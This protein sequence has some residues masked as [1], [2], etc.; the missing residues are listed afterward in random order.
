MVCGPADHP[1]EMGEE[2]AKVMKVRPPYVY[3]MTWQQ[4]RERSA[5]ICE[6]GGMF[7]DTVGRATTG[8]TV[9]T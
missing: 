7:S 3:S 1:F 8:G 5:D 4:I 9:A 6:W 2:I